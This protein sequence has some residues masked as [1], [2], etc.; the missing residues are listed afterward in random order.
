MTLFLELGLFFWD[1]LPEKYWQLLLIKKYFFELT[2]VEISKGKYLL[3][4]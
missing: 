3:N 4:F 1:A 2:K